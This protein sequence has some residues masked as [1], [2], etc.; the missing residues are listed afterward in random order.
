MTGA[1]SIDSVTFS[2]PTRSEVQ[3]LQGLSLD[4]KPG[5]TLALVG[6]SGCGKST[7]VSLLERFY[8]PVSGSVTIDG[9]DCRDAQLG[10]LRS[11]LGLVSQEPI[12]FD[13]TIADNI[14][15]GALFKDVSEDEII[16]AAKQA[17][18]HNFIETLPMV[19][20]IFIHLLK[21]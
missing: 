16:S 1:V 13:T 7:I 11:Q 14:R 9:V 2:Y 15:Y 20:H 8:D 6:P 18:I 21:F 10:W 19:R 3:V 12:L 4:L 5:Q 17:N